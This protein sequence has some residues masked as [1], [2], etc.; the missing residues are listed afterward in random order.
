MLLAPPDTSNPRIKSYG[1]AYKE[2]INTSRKRQSSANAVVILAAPDVDALCGV[3]ILVDMLKIDGILHNVRVVSGYAELENV[4]GEIVED[5]ELH[6]VVI[7]GFGSLLTLSSQFALHSGV[8]VHLVDS[9][10]PWNLA[11]AFG[12]FGGGEYDEAKVLVWDDGYYNAKEMED[13]KKSWEALEYDPEDSEDDSEDSEDSLDDDSED[14]NDNGVADSDEDAN[15]P[16][17]RARLNPKKARKKLKQDRQVHRSKLSKYYNSGSSHGMSVSCVMYILT[18]ELERAVND[19]VWY[20]ILGLTYQYISAQISRSQYDDRYVLLRDEVA[21]LNPPTI[22]ETVTNPDDYSISIKEELRF[23]LLR[24]WSLYDSM[25]HSEY[26]ASKL[27]IWKEGGKKRL[28]GF[29]AEM[30]L[31]LVQAQQSY[32]HMDTDLKRALPVKVENTAPRHQLVDLSY[33][34][35]VRSFGLRS[36]PLAAA[37]A[38]EAINAL[39]QAAT[40]INIYVDDGKGGGEL[41]SN[42]RLWEITSLFG[43]TVDNKENKRNL[44]FFGQMEE[45]DEDI[46]ALIKKKN[47]ERSWE[48][49][50]WIA[51]D[52]LN[53]NVSRLRASIPLCISLH[54]A[55]LRTGASLIEQ[56]V[57]RN[58]SL[59][60]LAILKEGPDLALFCNPAPLSRL[61]KWLIEALRDRI[62]SK[63]KGGKVID[64]RTGSQKRLKD[65]PFIVG[66]L[67]EKTGTYLVAGMTG[68]TLFDDARKNKLGTVFHDA[69]ESTRTR[70]K[71]DWFD[72][73]VVE[74]HGD[75]LQDFIEGVQA[76]LAESN[77]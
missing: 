51:Y 39:L 37:D 6:S 19:L 35:F 68:S 20:A 9:S 54:R 76:G 10:R 7:L 49:N 56:K 32:A 18:V 63:T 75:D 2:I 74:I 43:N 59:F 47:D 21:R 16:A 34:S 15:P 64:P 17:K 36:L 22:G 5:P 60:R 24:H 11:N 62:V 73:A 29:L 4:R 69:A 61:T 77:Y 13:L 25:I 12:G 67:N 41:F 65:L 8:T 23:P 1:S 26:I 70:S 66:C 14:D 42:V 45:G 38:V 72:T 57:I 71:H 50:F 40:G 28:H 3:R 46:T 48:R 33:P 52:A 31:P 55:V 27:G 58:L 44:T 53:N 30:G